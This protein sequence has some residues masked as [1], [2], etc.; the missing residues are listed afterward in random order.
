MVD[1]S[2]ESQIRV[3]SLNN[4][5][6]L[7][8]TDSIKSPSGTSPNSVATFE[9]VVA[10]AYEAEVKQDNGFVTFYDAE[11]LEEISSVTVGPLPDMLKFTPDGTKVLVANEGEPDFEYK[12]DPEGSVS[13]I[14]LSGGAENLKQSDVKTFGFE[15]YNSKKENLIDEGAHISGPDG[16]TVAQDLEPEYIAISEDS[17]TAWVSLQENNAIAVLDLSRGKIKNVYGL[18]FKDHSKQGNGFDPNDKNGGKIGLWPVFG[19]YQPDTIASYEVGGK[20]YI[21]TANEGDPRDDGDF[22]EYNEQTRVKDLKDLDGIKGLA[23]DVFESDM[24]ES[25]AD[26]KLGRLYVCNNNGMNE[27]GYFE[28]LYSFGTRSFSIWNEDVEQVYDSGDEFEQTTLSK[29]GEEYFNV[30][31]NEAIESDARSDKNGPSPEA[32]ALGQIGDKYFAFIGLEK[33]GGIMV[34]DITDP[35]NS[36]LVEYVQDRDYTINPEDMQNGEDPGDLG[37]EGYYF[38]SSEDSPTH[39]PLLLTANEVSGTVT[40]YKINVTYEE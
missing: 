20:N 32:L 19:M 2:E 28:A 39:K 1:S 29:L 35:E 30:D 6:E 5:G 37:P 38:I 3:L 24:D 7:S 40:V 8:F 14:D 21:V 15:D 22:E 34:Y 26:G 25:G 31:N 27:E 10:V 18:G 16:T 9:G 36:S 17:K 23:P 11:S 4:E 33:Q 12:N 13:L